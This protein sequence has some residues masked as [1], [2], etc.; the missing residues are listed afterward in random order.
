MLPAVLGLSAQPHPGHQDGDGLL[1][2]RMQA[3]VAPRYG[4]A[5]GRGAAGRML[6]GSQ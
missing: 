6:Q 4:W 3:G 1:T 5:G 2:E